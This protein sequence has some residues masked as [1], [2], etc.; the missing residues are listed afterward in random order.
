VPIGGAELTWGVSHVPGSTGVVG[1]LGGSQAGDVVERDVAA[2]NM[3]TTWA[4]AVLTAPPVSGVDKNVRGTLTYTANVAPS[5][6][7]WVDPPTTNTGTSATFT[8]KGTLPHPEAEDASSAFQIEITRQD[9]GTVVYNQTVTPTSGELS[10]EQFTRGVTLDAPLRTHTAR[11]RHYDTFGLVSPWSSTITFSAANAAPNAGVWQA[12][13]EGETTA[14][15]AIFEGLLGNPAGDVSLGDYTEAYDLQIYPTA[16]PTSYFVNDTTLTTGDEQAQ[17]YFERLVSGLTS[18]V[19]YGARYRQRD[20]MGLYGSWS[21]VLTFT[22]SGASDAPTPVSPSGLH[23][24]VSGFSYEAEY[25]HP[26]DLDAEGYQIEL[27]T[28]AGTLVWD[29]GYIVQAIPDETSIVKA[30]SHADLVRGTAYK[31]RVRASVEVSGV[32]TWTPWSDYEDFVANAVPN[33]PTW[34]NPPSVGSGSSATFTLQGYI[35]NHTTQDLANGDAT[36]QIYLNVYRLSPAETIYSQTLTPTSQ[37]LADGYFSRQVTLTTPLVTAYARFRTRDSYLLE[38]NYSPVI[39][40]SAANNA[41]SVGAFLS[42][43]SGGVTSTSPT[44]QGTLTAPVADEALGDYVQSYD[45]QVYPTAAPTS[46]AVNSNYATTSAE[47]TAGNFTRVVAGLTAG[48]A[49]TARYRQRDSMGVWGDWASVSFTAT[50]GPNAP[51][52]LTPSGKLNQ[53]SGHDYTALYTHPATVAGDRVQVQIYNGA[54]TALLYDSGE[55][56]QAVSDNTTITVP[57]FHADLAVGTSYNVRVRARSTVGGVSSWGPYSTFQSFYVNSPPTAASLAPSGDAYTPTLTLTASVTDAN[58]DAVTAAEA[59][60]LTDADVAT[61]G[62]PYTGVLSGTA[63]N[64]LATFTIPSGHVTLG[65]RYK[66]RVR[67]TDGH[68]TGYGPWT[69]YAFYNYQDVPSVTAVVP[70]PQ[71]VSNPTLTVTYAH[72]SALTRT[73]SRYDLERFVD[74]AWVAHYASPWAANAGAVGSSYDEAVPSAQIRNLTDYRIRFWARDTGGGEG[75]SPYYEFAT[76]YPS[77][78]AISI[79][80]AVGDPDRAEIALGWDETLLSPEAFGGIEVRRT[81]EGEDLIVALITDPAA[82]GWVDPFPVSGVAYTYHVRQIENEGVEQIDGP[83]STAEASVEYDYAFLK[84]T[85]DPTQ[86]VAFEMR[87]ANLLSPSDEEASAEYLA[88]GETAPSY[89]ST[90]LDYLSGELTMSFFPESPIDPDHE[91]RY[92]TAR[93]IVRSGATLCLLYQVPREGKVFIKRKGPARTMAQSPWIPHRALDYAFSWVETTYRE[94]YYE[95]M[96]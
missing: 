28:A 69:D 29:S 45:L 80:S 82:T 30:E 64:Q 67:A 47:R 70:T 57:E 86:L 43:A 10:A 13:T 39:P 12:P 27:R 89:V 92:E 79:T 5:Q 93:A 38:S 71:V 50:A 9:T 65:T 55:V 31:W 56:V 1:L 8:L 76:D 66:W 53:L 37:E 20:S 18:G 26:L 74:G 60:L 3:P 83:Y 21:P 17:G 14:T 87:A 96:G 7:A 33:T 61:S 52:S 35:N 48:T 88:W 94:D 73:H 34:R 58:G 25:D 41:P 32:S 6:G 24:P 11:F 22:A 78:A 2:G 63:P 95:R 51:T 68:A 72:P 49:Y 4:G 81:S 36:S 77:P 19:E 85:A 44:I 16:A 23:N 40:F 59:E 42:P 84:S 75:T 91:A 62:S 90:T 54:A 46:F 15:S